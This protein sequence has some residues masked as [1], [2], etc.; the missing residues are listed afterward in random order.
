M[1]AVFGGYLSIKLPKKVKED[2]KGRAV[3]MEAL[4]LAK[5]NYP[6]THFIHL[7]NIPE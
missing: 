4:K 6:S 1:C 5:A 7:L 3:A 2:S